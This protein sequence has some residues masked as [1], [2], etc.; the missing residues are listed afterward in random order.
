MN[1]Y[2]AGLRK[3]ARFDGRAHR[4]EFWMFTLVD[5]V[6]VT[7]LGGGALAIALNSDGGY[8]PVRLAAGIGLVLYGL[9]TVLPSLAVRVRRLHDTGRS[10]WYL[11]WSFLPIAGP[12]IVLV[13][14]CGAGTRGPNAYG[15]DPKSPQW[16]ETPGGPA[17]A[18]PFGQPGTPPAPYTPAPYAQPYAPVQDGQPT[19]PPP[20]GPVQGG[21]PATA[22]VAPA[23]G[24]RR[25]NI[26]AAVALGLALLLVCGGVI[27]GF[28]TRTAGTTTVTAAGTPDEARPKEDILAGPD[29]DSAAEPGSREP[30]PST[31][32]AEK[33]GDLDRVCNY[34]IF[35]PQSPKRSGKAPHPIV[36]LVDDGEDDRTDIRLRNGSYFFESEG[37]TDDVRAIWGPDDPNTVQLVACLDRVGTGAKVRNCEYGDPA[38][39]TVSLMAA[40]W[41]LRVYEAATGVK[42]H[43]KTMPGDEKKCPYSVRVGPDRKIYAEVSGR[44]LTAALRGYVK[45]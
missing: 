22:P 4:T 44:T 7:I 37:L 6:I 9:G 41:Q 14:L 20:Y 40:D 28:V 12:I 38:P 35:Y 21:R 17:A 2:L 30:G 5:A 25:T 13:A 42:I 8:F 18:H 16:P 1:W 33:I 11:C 27:R 3:Y 10:G 23:T 39:E 19:P 32:P 43:D 34:G 15:P 31:Y 26:I 29:A 24:T 36:V 45:K